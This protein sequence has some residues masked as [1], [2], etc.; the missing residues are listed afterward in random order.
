M[1]LFSGMCTLRSLVVVFRRFRRTYSLHRRRPRYWEIQ[2]SWYKVVDSWTLRHF[3]TSAAIYATTRH[4]VPEDLNPP[5]YQDECFESHKEFF[6]VDPCFI[7]S[8]SCL[9]SFLRN[10][11]YNEG[12]IRFR[13]G[14]NWT[15]VYT[16][17]SFK[18][19]SKCWNLVLMLEM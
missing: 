8:I 19:W 16:K 6:V 18:Q 5:K 17:L 15:F 12:C 10:Y 3:E 7:S 1:L 4:H 9:W 13:W 2:V 14:G 11:H